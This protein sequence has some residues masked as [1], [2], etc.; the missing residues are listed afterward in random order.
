[1]DVM[2]LQTRD[3]GTAAA[4]NRGIADTLT[5]F[6]G[7]THDDCVVAGDWLGQ[8]REAL[9]QERGCIVTGQ[10]IPEQGRGH[11]PSTV[12]GEE[13][14]VFRRPQL[15]ADRLY[16]AN[17]ALPIELALRVGPFDEDPRLRLAEDNDW[18]Y[19]A[20]RKG[21]PIVFRPEPR[22]T[23]IAWRSDAEL[24]Q[25][26]RQYA[27]SQGALYGKY[28]RRCDGF[29]AA[30]AVLD[31]T[32]RGGARL[33]DLVARR[34]RGSRHGSSGALALGILDG[35]GQRWEPEGPLPSPTEAARV[36]SPG[37]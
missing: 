13:R 6:L 30:R 31:F 8:L 20:L 28:I 29:M 18:S 3:V 5:P 16:P 26:Y 7:V 1:M 12:T 2:V 15:I 17:M 35:L 32:R 33:H 27:R 21:V 23:H 19:R 4:M 11:V 24:V 36:H 22:V 9:E 37:E 34:D 14:L 10:V 25:T